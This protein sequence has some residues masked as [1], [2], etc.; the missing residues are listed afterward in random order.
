MKVGAWGG[1]IPTVPHNIVS[2]RN[3]GD[4]LRPRVHMT[5]STKNPIPH[6]KTGK[7]SNRKISLSLYFIIQPVMEPIGSFPPIKFW[8]SSL[9]P[10]TLD[11]EDPSRVKNLR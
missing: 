4:L 8:A 7:T 3:S 10:G 6:P 5:E 9:S 11:T 2:L 1:S